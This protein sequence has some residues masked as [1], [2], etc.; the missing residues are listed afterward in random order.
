MKK[1]VLLLDC[2]PTF[3]VAI[4]DYLS[5]FGHKIIITD[6]IDAA[7]Q[8]MQDSLPTILFLSVHALSIAA[9]GKLKN[10]TETIDKHAKIVAIT[11]HYYLT[12]SVAI[13]LLN[14]PVFA[15]HRNSPLSEF[16]YFLQ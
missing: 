12:D 2:D 10:F 15:I 9:P 7:I 13:Q 1:C 14:K 6:S 16:R 3:S 11:H 8:C 5:S 4:K